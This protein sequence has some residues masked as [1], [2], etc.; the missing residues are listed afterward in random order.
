MKVAELD[1][2]SYIVYIR[3]TREENQYLFLGEIK[4]EIFI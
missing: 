1:F 3:G 2:I 4:M